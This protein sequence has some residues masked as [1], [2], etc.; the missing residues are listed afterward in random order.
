M[1]VISNKENKMPVKYVFACDIDYTILVYWKN[2]RELFA[3]D[4]PRRKFEPQLLANLSVC[5]I[6]P[7]ED[8][9]AYVKF[10]RK[11]SIVYKNAMQQLLQA[12]SR[13]DDIQVIFITA[14]G[15]PG[16]DLLPLLEQTFELPSGYLQQWLPLYRNADVCNA[17]GLLSVLTF[18]K[19]AILKHMQIQGLIPAA[20]KTILL[21][22]NPFY[23][24][25]VHSREFEVICAT[26]I[27][28]RDDLPVREEP[29]AYFQRVINALALDLTINPEHLTT[30]D[31]VAT[32]AA[33]QR[34][35][36]KPTLAAHELT[37]SLIE[38]AF[39]DPEFLAGKYRATSPSSVTTVATEET[40][41]ETTEEAAGATA[42][43]PNPPAKRFLAG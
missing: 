2:M 32:L 19:T 30:N 9:S 18:D 39:N 37:F 8:D 34:S 26:G 6:L 36:Q 10:F 15:H 28:V 29:H 43:R 33:R 7:K 3:N 31:L 12:C 38:E 16:E 41:P 20:A 11:C 21:D 17:M 14:G 13:R 27:L 42:S 24:L 23:S 5:S 22:D 4:F 40:T 1:T 35:L 25:G